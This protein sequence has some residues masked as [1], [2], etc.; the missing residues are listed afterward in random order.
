MVVEQAA[1]EVF[2][3][4]GEGSV[5]DDLAGVAAE[6]EIVPWRFT[7]IYYRTMIGYPIKVI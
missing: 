6:G 3:A 4:G 5:A 2:F 1:F 7:H